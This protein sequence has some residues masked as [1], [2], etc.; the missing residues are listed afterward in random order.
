MEGIM[1]TIDHVDFGLLGFGSRTL[2]LFLG[3]LEQVLAM[4][5]A[6][7]LVPSGVDQMEFWRD[8][9]LWSQVLDLGELIS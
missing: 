7:Q 8:Q 3:C 6:N 2:D 5:I 9:K 1:A 4:L